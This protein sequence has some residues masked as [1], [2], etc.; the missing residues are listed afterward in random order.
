MATLTTRV[1]KLEERL[2][3]RPCPDHPSDTHIVCYDSDDEY[4]SKRDR[5]QE[6]RQSCEICQDRPFQVIGFTVTKKRDFREGNDWEEI[7][8]D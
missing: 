1:E 8:D 7:F 5:I 3:R 4:A 2:G 6:S